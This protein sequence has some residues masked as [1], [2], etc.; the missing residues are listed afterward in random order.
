M[1]ILH[2]RLEKSEFRQLTAQLGA[3]HKIR[4]ACNESKQVKPFKGQ[5]LSV[6]PGQTTGFA[7]WLCTDSQVILQAAGQLHTPDVDHLHHNY[8][9]A[10][11][12]DRP[13]HM[14][15]ERYAV[16]SW[17]TDQHANSDV[18]TLRII[19]ALELLAIQQNITR[20]QQTAQV[21]KAFCTDDFL[22]RY[23]MYLPGLK[24]ARDAIRHGAYYIMFGG[25]RNGVDNN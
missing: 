19:G 17:K 22:K 9:V 5:L 6:D 20:S 16:Y 25:T 10:F 4:Q 23:S 14:V 2:D 1:A 21:A 7:L 8:S 18:P 15:Y 11:K 24:H 13:D 3:F 12:A